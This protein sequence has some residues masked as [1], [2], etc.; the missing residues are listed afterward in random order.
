ML[1]PVKKDELKDPYVCLLISPS[2]LNEVIEGF[3][4]I[5]KK[6]DDNL[7]AVRRHRGEV[8]AD[9]PVHQ[10]IVYFDPSISSSLPHESLIVQPPKPII[11]TFILPIK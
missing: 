6:R 4:A 2:L 10:R 1:K 5:C 9:I 8:A 3:N 7:K 11:T